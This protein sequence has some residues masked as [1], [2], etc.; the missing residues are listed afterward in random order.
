MSTSQ[1]SR[2]YATALFELIQGGADLRGDLAKVAAVAAVDEVAAFLASP[3]AP[4]EAK[5]QVIV[6]AAGGVSAELDRL[7]G[8]LSERNKASLLP[9][10]NSFVEEMLQQAE[11]E[12]EADIVVANA[13]DGALQKKLSSALGAST[14]KKVRLNVSEDKSIL[15]GMVVRIGDRKID[16]S[17]RTKLS[18]LRRT[19]AS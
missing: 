4:A 7:V 12:V 10:I 8:M 6:K 19:L 13:I 5:R 3:D 11:S 1:I 15:G 18:G 16:Y 17:L 9:E 14:G 2:R